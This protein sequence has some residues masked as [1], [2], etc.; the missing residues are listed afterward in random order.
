M[1][2]HARLW[3]AASGFGFREAFGLPGK[4]ARVCKSAGILPQ[5]AAQNMAAT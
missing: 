1:L 5:K 2:E 4:G 3:R